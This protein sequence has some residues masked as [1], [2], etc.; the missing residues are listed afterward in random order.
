MYNAFY[1]YKPALIGNLKADGGKC[2][3]D[4]SALDISHVKV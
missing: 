1:A 3:D 2:N 4:A